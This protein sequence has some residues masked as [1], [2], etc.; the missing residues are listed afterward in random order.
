MLKRGED[1]VLKLKPGGD[2]VRE[3]LPWN[4]AQIPKKW[5]S[6]RSIVKISWRC[7]VNIHIQRRY[8][9]D[10]HTERPFCGTRGSRHRFLKAVRYR[11]V[12]YIVKILGRWLLSKDIWTLTFEPFC[13]LEP[14]I[15]M[16]HLP[17]EQKGETAHVYVCMCVCVCVCV[18]VCHFVSRFF[19]KR[20]CSVH[21]SKTRCGTFWYHVNY[22]QVICTFW[23][24]VNNAK[25][26]WFVHRW[27]PLG[28]MR[29]L[30]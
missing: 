7:I 30:A 16:L 1:W 18:C 23:N 9:K 5:R 25:N 6:W 2:N 28:A 12:L 29:Q 20:I 10:A 13:Q 11:N 14:V 22:E 17:V 19:L 15:T 24:H 8:F 21:H 27:G 4:Q 26:K 3:G